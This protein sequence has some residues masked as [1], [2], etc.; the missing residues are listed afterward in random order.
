MPESPV[1]EGSVQPA[2]ERKRILIVEGDGFTRIVLIF[3]FRLAGFAVD[4]TSNVTLALGK[5][6][7]S[8]PDALLVDL[9][10]PVVSGMELIRTARRE[11]Q[12]GDRPIYVFTDKDQMSRAIQMEVQRSVTR[13]FDKRSTVMEDLL[14]IIVTEV[15]GVQDPEPFGTRKTEKPTFEPPV[16]AVPPGDIDEII[17]GVHEECE[18]WL[19]SSGPGERVEGCDKLL[20]RLR[21]LLSCAQVAGLRNLARQAKALEE[22]LNQFQ[23]GRATFNKEELG[24]IGRAVE[25]LSSLSDGDAKELNQFT[26][27]VIDESP[28]SGGALSVALLRAGTKPVSFEDPA[29]ALTYLASNPVELVIANLAVPELHGFDSALSQ[30]PQLPGTPVIVVSDPMPTNDPDWAE[31]AA[32]PLNAKSR[33]RTGLIM[34]TLTELQSPASRRTQSIAASPARGAIAREEATPNSP[35]SAPA[36]SGGPISSPPLKPW[37]QLL[38]ARLKP[39]LVSEP[40]S[41]PPDLQPASLNSVEAREPSNQATIFFVEDD[42]FVLKVYTKALERA[43][44]RVETAGDGLAAF[45]LLPQ[46]RPALVVL[47]LMLPKVDGLEVLQFVRADSDL[48]DTPVIVLSNSYVGQLAARAK[49]AGANCGLSKAD[50]TP[51]K[52]V[53][54][55]CDLLRHPVPSPLFEPGLDASGAPAPTGEEAV[56][57]SAMETGQAAL[58]EQAPKEVAKLRRLCLSCTRAVDSEKDLVELSELYRRV[59]FLS[60]R[61]ALIGF[62]KIAD[63]SSVLE[64]LLFE[65][66]FKQSQSASST[67]QTITQAVDFLDQLVESNDTTFAGPRPE[68]KVLVVDSDAAGNV[69][70]VR[71]LQRGHFEVLGAQ[72]PAEGIRMLQGGRFDAVTM[73]IN[74]PAQDGFEVYQQLRLMPQH[75]T[76]PVLFF[77]ANNELQDLANSVISEG[78]DVIPKGACA[79]EVVL[80]LIMH[81]LRPGGQGFAVNSGPPGLAGSRQPASDPEGS[82]LIEDDSNSSEWQAAPEPFASQEPMTHQSAAGSLSCEPLQG[83]EACETPQ[84]EE[85]VLAKMS[86]GM[87]TERST[88]EP[89]GAIRQGAAPVSETPEEQTLQP[90]PEAKETENE[91][92]AD[93]DGVTAEPAPL[94]QCGAN[95]G[96]NQNESAPAFES[97]APDRQGFPPTR[98]ARQAESE[99]GFVLDEVGAEPDLPPQGDAENGIIEERNAP[100]PDATATE[101]NSG[102]NLV[103]LLQALQTECAKQRETVA[104]YAQERESLLERIV[105][106]ENDLQRQGFA[107]EQELEGLRQAGEEVKGQLAKEQ[108]VNA[109]A[110]KRVKE[111]ESQLQSGKDQAAD[112][113]Q[114]ISQRVATLTR[115]TADLAKERGERHRI[116]ER[117]AALNQRLQELHA[118]SKLLLESQRADQERIGTLED[119]LRQREEALARQ[120]VEL[121]HQKAECRLAEEQLDKTNDLS[122]HLH[123]HLSSF[124][125]ARKTLNSTQ[126]ELQSRLDAAL[127]SLQESGSKL[128]GENAERERLATELEEARRE[129]QNHSRKYET[130]GIELQATLKALGESESKLQQETAERQRLA[131]A[132]DT[133]QRELQNQGRTRETLDSDFKAASEGLRESES[134]VQQETAERQRLAQ[135]LE[136][137]QRNHRDH[138][139][140]AEL[141]LSKAQCALQFE[142]VERERLVAQMARLQHASLD[143]ERGTR[144]QRN[145]WRK[146]IQEPVDNLYKGANSLLQLEMSEEQKKLAEAILRDVLM[147]QNTLQEPETPQVEPREAASKADP[148]AGAATE[149]S[150][151]P[152]E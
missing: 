52:L 79:L 106:A 67:F 148:A 13:V 58:R 5:F 145:T 56:L 50:C 55:V 75:Q 102:R 3:L 94:L 43:G 104:K 122:A 35:G 49:E 72:D 126:Q 29:Q 8:L 25:L 83:S 121:E 131:A 14:N 146:Q 61:A 62:T 124:D 36:D 151:A 42:P 87:V 18:L 103:E 21:S 118:E 37:G 130:L 71:G 70:T 89:D 98:Q 85:E 140:R 97:K 6:R 107:F 115:V 26:V 40:A 116:E 1:P 65:L 120:T 31:P 133:A 77:S 128:E 135:A 101:P 28:L 60:A 48:K 82:L 96:T 78:N 17:G 63:V 47:D 81:T 86:A 33:L 147:V 66:M 24:M 22:F 127:N 99:G 32:A 113:E 108:Q 15:S 9:K 69:A 59:R 12:F 105:N 129:L 11:P 10:L 92:L 143:A 110:S 20:S 46:L 45:E 68:L 7:A 44:F 112:L 111:L 109:D 141:E 27:G 137:A 41:A 53:Q 57:E 93:T 152:P 88:D 132:L 64:G 95:N 38:Q 144:L 76:V 142:Q 16:N 136:S 4:F 73:D 23:N 2:K 84:A 91:W 80:R 125:V 34:K 30:F 150:S 51:A 39:G 138:S 74:T 119:Q 19:N 117:A 139:Q 123:K 114:G 90:A 54:H 149:G 134:R 100:V